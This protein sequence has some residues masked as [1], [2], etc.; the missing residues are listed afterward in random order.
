MARLKVFV[1]DRGSNKIFCTQISFRVFMQQRGEIPR[2]VHNKRRRMKNTGNFPKTRCP[3]N[4]VLTMWLVSPQSGFSLSCVIPH[5]L[6]IDGV[7]SPPMW[8]LCFIFF[9]TGEFTDFQ[10]MEMFCKQSHFVVWHFLQNL[11]IYISVCGE[12]TLSANLDW[13]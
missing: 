6:V 7:Y 12:I 9:T 8:W 10:K 13:H 5:S 4:F 11:K 2:M 1:N 3:Q